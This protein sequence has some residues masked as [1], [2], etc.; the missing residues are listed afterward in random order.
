[1]K[2]T[3]TLTF[4]IFCTCMLN[5]QTLVFENGKGKIYEMP[6][7][8]RLVKARIKSADG[9]TET[10]RCNITGAKDA[11]TIIL[12]RKTSN[13]ARLKEIKKDSILTKEEKYWAQYCDTLYVNKADIISL[14]FNMKETQ[15]Y[16]PLSDLVPS[17]FGF[18]AGA[19]FFVFMAMDYTA[20]EPGKW[21][22]PAYLAGGTSVICFIIR[23]KINFKI[24]RSGK[25]KVKEVKN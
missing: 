23:Q 14:R 3:A 13:E 4:I 17:A 25:W 2:K 24:M 1:M 16:K 15:R 20:E 22:M 18:I 9:K 8:A 12:V 21:Q 19:G 6:L 5:A 11:S 7:P 10:F